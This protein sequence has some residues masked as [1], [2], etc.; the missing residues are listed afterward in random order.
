MGYSKPM[1]EVEVL[2][3]DL[4]AW[5]NFVRDE[6]LS[7]PKYGPYKRWKLFRALVIEHLPAALLDRWDNTASFA[8]V[9]WAGYM[10]IS[11]FQRL[12]K[13]EPGSIQSKFCE[14]KLSLYANNDDTWYFL[15]IHGLDEEAYCAQKPG[16]PNKV[17]QRLS[18]GEITL[19]ALYTQ[20]PAFIL[21]PL[22]PSQSAR[23]DAWN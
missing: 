11:E 6:Q 12:S 10:A 2:G 23:K 15:A 17:F 20:H 9:V 5:G 19:G 4:G 16:I 8:D 3:A 18:K 13:P 22:I 14:T 1:G 7:D 21:R